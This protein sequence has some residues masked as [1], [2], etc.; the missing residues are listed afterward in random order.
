MN[1][2]VG[3]EYLKQIG[4]LDGF[5]YTYRESSTCLWCKT[6]VAFE[7]Q[8]FKTFD[9]LPTIPQW[10]LDFVPTAEGFYSFT[11]NRYIYQYRDHLG[12]A[13]VSFGK[14]SEGVLETT[15]T[16]N[17]YPFGLNHIGG[18]GHAQLG[19]YFNYKYNGKELQ[20]TGM[21]DYGARMY[22]PDIGRWGVVDPLAEKSR[23]FSPY[24]YAL[25][26]PIMFVDPDGREAQQCCAKYW[27]DAW[28]GFKQ[29]AQ[30]IVVGGAQ[31]AARPGKIIGITI[32][33]AINDAKAGRYSSAADKITNLTHMGTTDMVKNAFKAANGDG[34]AA[35]TLGAQGLA[36]LAAEGAG[37]I[38]GAGK[39]ARSGAAAEAE[40]ANLI[41]AKS[42]AP[43]AGE[44]FQSLGV[45]VSDG[46][47]SVGGRSVANGRFDFVVTESGELKVGSGHYYLSGGANEVQAAGQLR[48]YKGQVMEIN[49]ASGHYQPSV[50]EAKSFP[51][52]LSNMGIDVSKAKL[53]AYTAD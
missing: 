10:D 21:Y 26:N 14:N 50:I 2:L 18:T 36:V 41:S 52:I 22:M 7:Q 1:E 51:S 49:N 31:L 30:N 44:A 3:L 16:N 17:Y 9:P 20:E 40:S 4:Y 13:R 24:T 5:Q 27:K 47:I 32:G 34:K 46:N 35:G 42:T 29:E 38:A 33:G 19:S 37:R 12:N 15:D 48:L 6:E 11:E 45:S 53:K 28:T 23:R 43:Q 25:D 39:G 8:A